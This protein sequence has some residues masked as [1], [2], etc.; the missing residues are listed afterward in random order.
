MDD[1]LTTHE[2]E[3]LLKL[4]R[5]TIYRMIKTGR[6]SGVRVGQ[7][8]RFPRQNVEA[9]LSSENPELADDPALEPPAGLT[10]DILPLHCM[11]AIQ[12]VFA[13]LAQ[14]GA[15]TTRLDGMPLTEISNAGRLWAMMHATAAGRQHCI[16][17]WRALAERSS[18]APQVDVCQSGL[19]CIYARIE[20]DEQPDA[21]L[22]AG[23]F[24][25]D[26][27]TPDLGSLARALGQHED[28]LVAAA[29]ATP[30]LDA[31]SRARVAVCLQKVAQTFETIG[32]ERAQMIGRLRRIA[33]LSAFDE[34][35][36]KVTIATTIDG[37][38]GSR[39]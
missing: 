39:T 36:S 8:W 14:I 31:A 35:G 3:A 17:T 13:E 19:G 6:L 23:P 34:L 2:V 9:L 15:V 4:D 10:P 1:L 27:H 5:T 24:R 22:V 16:S 32:Q 12:D 11:Q 30:Y 33:E 26:D 29:N 38:Q 21:L 20:L 28:N 18:R 7:Q 37:R 25:I